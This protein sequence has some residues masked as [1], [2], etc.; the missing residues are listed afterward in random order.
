[1]NKKLLLLLPIIVLFVMGNQCDTDHLVSGT[2][3]VDVPQPEGEFAQINGINYFRIIQ[4]G[5]VITCIALDPSTLYDPL[6]LPLDEQNLLRITP[7][8]VEELTNCPQ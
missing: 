4:E 5:I 8:S 6:F 2:V 3:T 7:Y 1:M